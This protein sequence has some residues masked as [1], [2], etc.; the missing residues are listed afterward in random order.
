M[1]IG[2]SNGDNSTVSWIW[3]QQKLANTRIFLLSQKVD[4]ENQTLTAI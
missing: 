1:V 2:Q 4:V 3:N